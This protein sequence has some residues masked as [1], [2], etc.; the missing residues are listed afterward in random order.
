[1]AFVKTSLTNTW[2]EIGAAGA[3][4]IQNAGNTPIEVTVGASAPAAGDKGLVLPE[5]GSQLSFTF[6]AKTWARALSAGTTGAVV[7]GSI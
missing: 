4:V 3:L 1:M 6:T 7:A 2:A 5:L